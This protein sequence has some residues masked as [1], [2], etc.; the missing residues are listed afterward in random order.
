MAIEGKVVCAPKLLVARAPG[1]DQFSRKRDCRYETSSVA[2]NDFPLPKVTAAA[3]IPNT[4]SRRVSLR[5][6]SFRLAFDAV[7]N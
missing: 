7:D 3:E 6:D 5:I 4:A 2:A 1:R